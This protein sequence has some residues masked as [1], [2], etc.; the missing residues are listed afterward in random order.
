MR[1]KAARAVV[2]ALAPNPRAT[3][4]SGAPTTTRAPLRVIDT[5]ESRLANRFA[6]NSIAARKARVETTIARALDAIA[7]LKCKH[8]QKPQKASF[9]QTI[10][11]DCR[12]LETPIVW[13]SRANCTQRSSKV[14]KQSRKLSQ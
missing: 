11:L 5:R 2:D 7:S 8:K 13:E 1:I 3:P 6:Q 4:S 10:L 12:K 14:A 9:A